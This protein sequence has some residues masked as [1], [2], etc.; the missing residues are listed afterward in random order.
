MGKVARSSRRIFSCVSFQRVCIFGAEEFRGTEIC[1]RANNIS[2]RH[3]TLPHF[4]I[5]VLFF[6]PK[7][8]LF[9]MAAGLAVVLE[10][11]QSS[12]VLLSLLELLSTFLFVLLL[13]FGVAE[14]FINAPSFAST[15]FRVITRR[16]RAALAPRD[17]LKE[18][19]RGAFIRDK[20]KS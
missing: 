3:S 7:P 1:R 12:E 19:K 10:K 6:P 20:L 17:A 18:I 9:V 11:R 13:S 15:R 2:G 4:Y 8:I 5:F 16:R 14:L